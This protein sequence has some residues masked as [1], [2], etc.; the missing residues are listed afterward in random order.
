M[1]ALAGVFIGLIGLVVISAVVWS[2][3]ATSPRPGRRWALVVALVW[4]SLQLLAYL[5][6]MFQQKFAS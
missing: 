6:V 1:I 5:S 3:R 4:A 2:R